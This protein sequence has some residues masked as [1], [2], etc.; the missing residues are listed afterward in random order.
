MQASEGKPV[1][2]RTLMPKRTATLYEPADGSRR[3]AGRP[4][5]MMAKGA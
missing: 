4:H 1:A 3:L 5:A 2:V